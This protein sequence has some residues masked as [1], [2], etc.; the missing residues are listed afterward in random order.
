M[1]KKNP[2]ILGLI[3]ALIVLLSSSVVWAITAAVFP[4]DD[5][6]RQHNSVDLAM[7]S[8][9]RAEVSRKGIDVV[10]QSKVMDFMARYNIRQ[11]GYLSSPIIMRARQALGAD[12]VVLASVCE[13]HKK[14]VA[15]GLTISLIRT[16]DGL[17]VWSNTRGLSQLAEQ[18]LLGINSP[19]SL[20]A[21]RS[22]LAGRIFKDWPHALNLPPAGP[23]RERSW[24]GFRK[25]HIFRWNRFCLPLNLSD[26]VR[27]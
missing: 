14:P 20:N 25:N 21:I 2:H 22:I 13:Q 3:A 1:K 23:W 4:V 18:H 8:F 16:S 24:P 17:T 19:D 9:L 26:L 11:L 5:L 10:A 15:M 6:S 7:T 27:I 12:L